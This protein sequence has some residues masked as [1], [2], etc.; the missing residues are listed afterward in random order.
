MNTSIRVVYDLALTV[1]FRVLH[2]VGMPTRHARHSVTETPP[3]RE[4]LDALRLRGERVRM[5]DLVI[6]GARERLAELEAE[7]DDEAHKAKLRRQLVER[8]RTGEGIDV[9]AAYE[10]REHG[11]IHR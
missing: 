10:V 6:R 3:V 2:I 5:D 7:R 9:D 11:W 4:A 1:L 8:L